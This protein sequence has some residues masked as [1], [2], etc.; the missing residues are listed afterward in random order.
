MLPDIRP[1]TG[2]QKR[3]DIWYKHNFKPTCFV[4][5]LYFELK[6]TKYDILF[7]SKAVKAPKTA[8]TDNRLRSQYKRHAVI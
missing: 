1:D 2:Y 3:P 5:Q 6:N 4:S 7:Y 8:S